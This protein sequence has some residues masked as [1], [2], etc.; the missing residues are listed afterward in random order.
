MNG[1]AALINIFFAAYWFDC[2]DYGWAM[3]SVAVAVWFGAKD[4]RESNRE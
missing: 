2:G 1:A 3:A 4:W